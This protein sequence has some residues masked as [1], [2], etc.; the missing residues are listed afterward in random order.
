LGIGLSTEEAIFV[1]RIR[2]KSSSVA[3]IG[4]DAESSVLEVEFLSGSVYQYFKV[5]EKTFK[6][7]L[8]AK[9]V[10]KYFERYIKK[11]GFRYSELK[12]HRRV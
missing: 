4:Y 2:V 6:G 3:S 8:K 11:A 5:P 1:N 10:G 9:S 7:I 12:Q